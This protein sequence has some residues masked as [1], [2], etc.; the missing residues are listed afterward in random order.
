V[1]RVKAFRATR[2]GGFIAIYLASL[3]IF[4]A[5][6]AVLHLVVAVLFLY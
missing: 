4:A 6:V 2:W 1:E 5:A 3:A